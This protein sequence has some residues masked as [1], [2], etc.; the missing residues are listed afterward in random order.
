MQDYKRAQEMHE[1]HKTLCEA[2]GD[3][4]GV[5]TACANLGFCYHSMGDYTLA[6]E[7]HERDRVTCEELGDK[8]GVAIACGNLGCCYHGLG[9]YTQA[10]DL[11]EEHRVRAEALGDH[12]G[13]ARACG[14]IG[15]CHMSRR[16]YSRALE[17]F[18]QEFKIAT[19]V[20]VPKRKADSAL[21]I[22]VTLRLR[23]RERL[24]L[25][26]SASA[27]GG[28]EAEQ[29]ACTEDEM[30]KA[31]S[32]LQSAADFEKKHA[33]LH[34]AC[35]HFDAGAEDIACQQLG[36]Y[37]SVS[38]EQARTH[39]AACSQT[40]GEDA[41]LLMCSGCRVARF[42][43]PQH[44]RMASVDTPRSRSMVFG[45]HNRVCALLGKWRQNVVKAGHAPECMRGDL[46]AF[47][48][49]ERQADC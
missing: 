35:L 36:K 46:V 23:L 48:Q 15:L 33:H 4:A 38:I 37:L 45:K 2:L 49:Q 40:R 18:M 3:R 10:Q 24:G 16:E 27:L 25:A 39:C 26:A 32:W 44:Q 17:Y 34:L 29:L 8:A 47:L 7:Y 30:R 12:K 19:L 20:Q 31:E 41:N 43:S 13:V 1:Q 9:N 28:Q 5:A 14:N 22:G 21:A 42:C 11:H 6:R